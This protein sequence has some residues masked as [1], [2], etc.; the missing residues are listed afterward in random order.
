M[1]GRGPT[2]KDRAIRQRTNRPVRGEWITLPDGTYRGPR[3]TLPRLKGGLLASTKE[4]WEAWWSSPMA[5]AWGRAQWPK[6]VRAIALADEVTRRQNRR[7]MAG[8]SSL[9]AELRQLE[10]SLGLSEKGRRDL[11]WHMPDDEGD[12]PTLAVVRELPSRRGPD[13]RKR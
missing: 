8:L 9:L 2:P 3:P 1:A 12:T 4:A 11:R 7:E 5:H 6:L 13:P 10:D